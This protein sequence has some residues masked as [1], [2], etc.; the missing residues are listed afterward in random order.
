M[1]KTISFLASV[2]FGL[3]VVAAF[4]IDVVPSYLLALMVGLPWAAFILQLKDKENAKNVG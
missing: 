2:S 1:K 4:F 3:A